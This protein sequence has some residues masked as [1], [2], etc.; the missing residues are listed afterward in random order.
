MQKELN[1]EKTQF[2]N[3]WN[4]IFNEKSWFS[5]MKHYELNINLDIIVNDMWWFSYWKPTWTPSQFSFHF[6]THPTLVQSFQSFHL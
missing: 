1:K 3:S 2:T 5:Q 4:L 6:Y